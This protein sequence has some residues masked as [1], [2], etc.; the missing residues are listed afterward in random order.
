M[1]HLTEGELRAYL[2]DEL[3][4][5]T[6]EWIQAHLSNCVKCRDKIEEVKTR[7]TYVRT[8]MQS[9]ETVL[10]PVYVETAHRRWEK[11]VKPAGVRKRVSF[12]NTRSRLVWTAVTLVLVMTLLLSLAPLRAL[13]NDFLALFRVQ[14]LEFVE[15]NPLNLPNSEASL[16][17]AAM[18]VDKLLD[19]EVELILHGD[20]QVVTQVAAREMTDFAVRFPDISGLVTRITLQPRFDMVLQ[21]DLAEIRTLFAAIGYSGVNFPQTLDGAVIQ[22]VFDNAVVT[23]MG[24]CAEDPSGPSASGDCT[25]FIQTPSPGITAPPELD[26]HQL[27]QLYLQMLGMKSSQADRF[28]RNI[29]W[30]TTLVVPIPS[31][32]A[33]FEDV[34]VDGV[35]GTIVTGRRY[36]EVV[37]MWVKNDIV[38]AVVGVGEADTLLDIANSLE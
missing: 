8:R 21:L 17:T 6:Q 18:E 28:S 36:N 16:R 22:A 7:G 14:K 10:M 29:D 23:A 2:D 19:E 38:Y 34:V 3:H 24:Q 31:T 9:L 27:G 15:F 13:A 37:L 1:R 5:G 32:E 25:I 26:L 4:T 33:T 12:F 30:T 11:Q 35:P 20:P